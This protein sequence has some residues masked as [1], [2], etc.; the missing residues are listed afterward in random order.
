MLEQDIYVTL[1]EHKIPI[2]KSSSKHT[3]MFTYFGNC[4]FLDWCG[5]NLGTKPKESLK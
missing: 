1:K 2:M 3:I 5:V 4:S